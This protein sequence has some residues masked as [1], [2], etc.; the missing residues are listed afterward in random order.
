MGLGSN[1]HGLFG[2]ANSGPGAIAVRGDSYSGLAGYFNGDVRIGGSLNKT[3][4]QFIIDHTNPDRAETHYLVHRIAIG[5]CG[6]VLLHQQRLSEPEWQSFQQVLQAI[7]E[8]WRDRRG[9]R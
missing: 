8:A 4:A 9:P 7:I 5:E 6:V 2:W 1:A 3:A